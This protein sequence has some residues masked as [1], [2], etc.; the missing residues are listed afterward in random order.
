M[1]YAVSWIMVEDPALAREKSAGTAY[2]VGTL[3]AISL[4]DGRRAWRHDRRAGLVSG[5]LATGGGL[6]FAGDANRR[7]AAFDDRSGALLWETI[8]SAPVTG[9]PITY[10]VDGVQ[11]VAVAAGGSTHADKTALSL[12][13]EIKSPQG[14]S[15]LF[16]FRL[17][18][19]TRRPAPA[20]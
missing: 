7:F 11:Y 13:P 18:D 1:G 10:S 4:D 16:V 8:L 15:T 14:L 6:V 2:P 12:H 3:T 17:R 9:H 20:R 5:L 19:G